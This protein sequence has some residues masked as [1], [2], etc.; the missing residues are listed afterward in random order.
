MAKMDDGKLRSIIDARVRNS[1]GW[2]GGLLSKERRKAER[3]YRGDLFGNEQEGRSQV[4]SRV[5][6]E[7]VDSMMPPLMKIF[8]SGDEIVTFEPQGPEDEQAAQ[9]A[10][11]YVNW[12]WQ[13]KNQSFKTF[14]WWF[15]DAL[16]FKTGWVKVWW[17]ESEKYSHEDYCGLTQLQLQMLEADPDVE[18]VELRESMTQAPALP[19]QPPEPL[20]D[21]TIKR[22]Q[23]D[24]RVCIANVPPE[25]MLLERR[26]V[27]PEDMGFI[28]HRKKY[29]ASE[30]LDLYP[31]KKSLIDNLPSDETYDFEA[32]TLERFRDDDE[33]PYRPTGT[34]DRS[35]RPIW[36]VESYIRVD[37]DGDGTAELRKVTTAGNAADSSG[38]ILDNEEVDDHPFCPL[39]P[40]LMPHKLLGWSIADQTM[41]L[42]L[43][44]STLWRGAMDSI[45]L[46]I[47]P[48]LQVLQGQANLDQL[49]KR[50]PGQ[51][52][53]TKIP[54]AVAP[55]ETQ[56]VGP[57]AF[58]M[59]QYIDTMREQRTGVQRFAAGPGA[60]AL[61]TAY[62]TTATGASMVENASQE[63]LELI[64]RTFAETG[65]KMAFRR[66]LEL[67]CR[68]QQ[69]PK[70]IR[71]RNQ[72]VP[73]DPSEWND[74]MDLT[75]NTGLGT[76]N[77]Q[78]QVGILTNL[79]ALDE[80]IVMLQGGFGGML[81]PQNVY[82]KLAKLCQA[83]GLKN[84]DQYYTD[85]AQSSPPPPKPD[86]NVAKAQAELQIRQQEAQMKAQLDQQ[87]AQHKAQLEAAQ[88][89]RQSQIESQQAQADLM[90][91]QQKAELQLAQMREEHALKMQQSVA[92]AALNR[93]MK[94]MDMKLKYR[95]AQ[96]QPKQAAQ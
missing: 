62:S 37:Y 3:Y 39:S 70:I 29:T 48:Q 2:E 57:E 63:R 42:Q 26:A 43:V 36:V 90:V 49:L 87:S 75:I 13:H 21:A 83:S 55:I 67:V 22:T 69:K 10:T 92:D 31:D 76:G 52:V 58:E 14:Y 1:L 8:C 56:P 53:E 30:L 6:A 82:H 11:D 80:K 9:Q 5:V 19:G 59:I 41:D 78:A 34:M 89:E 24:G 50:I 38:A 54:N 77:K 72:W 95:Q 64:A 47:A 85:P 28:A 25:E 7:A 18:I 86:P 35:T 81:T 60:N 96:Q 66:T 93:R 61:Q 91:Q 68:Y 71:L 65:V 17:E 44:Q 51:I 73:I 94:I 27:D 88:L 23:K 84:V 20:T 32:E 33:F 79:L 15:K 40:I 74:Q 16:L 12:I 46:S 45:Y 4:V